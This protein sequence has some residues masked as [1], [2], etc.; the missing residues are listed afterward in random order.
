MA[1]LEFRIQQLEKIFQDQD[2]E[3]FKMKGMLHS[4]TR[5]LENVS[6]SFRN[7]IFSQEGHSHEPKPTSLPQCCRADYVKSKIFKQVFNSI[8]D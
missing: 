4:T 7:Y 3:I 6:N 8:Y 5:K 2:Q 1:E